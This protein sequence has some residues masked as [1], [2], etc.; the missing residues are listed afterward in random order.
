VVRQGLIPVLAGLV[1][2][3]AVAGG[4]TRFMA[5]LLFGVDARDPM[6]FTTAA[7]VLLGVA[8]LAT[9]WPA[10]RAARLD[11]MVALRED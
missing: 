1:A 11:P 2:G 9:I 4:T 3:L 8:L 7:V 5:S 6:T 10:R